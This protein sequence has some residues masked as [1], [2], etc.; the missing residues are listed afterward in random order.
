M[1][2]TDF[3]A[4]NYLYIIAAIPI[5]LATLAYYNQNLLLYCNYLPKNSQ[6]T[7]TYLPS[8][9]NLPFED[10]FL[11]TRDNVRYVSVYV[12]VCLRIRREMGW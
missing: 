4:N 10:V 9:Y 2:I 6:G 3:L 11:T 12:C 1:F 5:C 8:R 7:Y